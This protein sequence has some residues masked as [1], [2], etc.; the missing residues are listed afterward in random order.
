MSL[1]IK[2]ARDIK[3]ILMAALGP[4]DITNYISGF[5]YAQ[6]GKRQFCRFGRRQQEGEDCLSFLQILRYKVNIVSCTG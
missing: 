2:K 6:A 5:V 1:S 4:N 3:F